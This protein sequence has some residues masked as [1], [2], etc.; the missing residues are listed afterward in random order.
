MQNSLVGREKEKTILQKAL[1]STNAASHIEIIRA[2]AKK[3]KGLTPAEIVENTTLSAGGGT[4]KV[5]EEL[6]HSGFISMYYPFGKKK[7]DSLYRLTDEYSLFY[8]Q[9]IENNRNQG[10]DIWQ[11]LSQTQSYISWASYSH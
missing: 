11:K 1:Q 7:K 2:L 4:T 5:L 6:L 10:S 8:L 9:F 3:R